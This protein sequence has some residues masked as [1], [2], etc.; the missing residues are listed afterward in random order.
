MVFAEVFALPRALTVA[1]RLRAAKVGRRV[2]ST[3]HVA[4]SVSEE[5]P[6]HSSSIGTT[7]ADKASGCVG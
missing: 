1:S 7:L 6:R 4:P 3:G 5:P 2:G